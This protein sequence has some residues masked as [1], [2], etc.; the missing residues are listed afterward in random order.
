VITGLASTKRHW[1]RQFW[2]RLPPLFH[3]QP[4]ESHEK[5]RSYFQTLQADAVARGFLTGLGINNVTLQRGPRLSAQWPSELY[6]RMGI[7]HG[8]SGLPN[9]NGTRGGRRFCPV[10]GFRRH[11]RGPADRLDRRMAKFLI[12]SVE[13]AVAIRGTRNRRVGGFADW[14]SRCCAHTLALQF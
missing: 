10:R 9:Q 4:I 7:T 11:Y 12:S 2:R 14:E 3:S 1:S 13:Q 6:P 8:T 5:N